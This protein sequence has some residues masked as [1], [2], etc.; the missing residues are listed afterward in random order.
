MFCKCDT[1]VIGPLWC[2]KAHPRCPLAYGTVSLGPSSHSDAYTLLPGNQFVIH[3][4]A[5]FSSSLFDFFSRLGPFLPPRIITTAPR[6]RTA[7]IKVSAVAA[8]AAANPTPSTPRSTK[9]GPQPDLLD[10]TNAAVLK[11][12]SVPAAFL[13][14][15]A[16]TLDGKGEACILGTLF[17]PFFYISCIKNF[18][19]FAF[20]FCLE[21]CGRVWHYV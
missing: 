3:V 11:W 8:G 4:P 5:V 6:G 13:T 17:P 18:I 20:K 21:A 16:F 10:K 14:A 9:E 1:H 7:G 2:L 19:L 15:V 12:L